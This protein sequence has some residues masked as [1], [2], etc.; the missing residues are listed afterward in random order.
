MAI[1][2]GDAAR[3]GDEVQRKRYAAMTPAERLQVALRLYWT[4][5]QLKD[6]HLRVLHPQLGEHELRRRVTE[7]FLCTRD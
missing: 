1:E 5:R 3:R 2:P 4:A 6:A 7:S